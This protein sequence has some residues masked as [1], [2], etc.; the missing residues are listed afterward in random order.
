M[1]G[2]C[3]YGDEPSG[4]GAKELFIYLLINYL[5]IHSLILPFILLI[6][7][8]THSFFTYVCI[9]KFIFPFMH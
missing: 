7:L 4:S 3:G 5:F 9:F 2:S 8:I 1:S 6:C